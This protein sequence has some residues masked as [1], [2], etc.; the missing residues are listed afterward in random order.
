MAAVAPD[1][2]EEGGSPV[3]LAHLLC[4]ECAA[5]IP[6]DPHRPGCSVAG[7]VEGSDDPRGD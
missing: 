5:V 2:D 3:C 6:E 1:A 7:L 4:P